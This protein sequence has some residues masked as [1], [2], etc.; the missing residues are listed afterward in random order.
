MPPVNEGFDSVVA[1][2][3]GSIA[4]VVASPQLEL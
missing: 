3:V 4:K 2:S 1:A